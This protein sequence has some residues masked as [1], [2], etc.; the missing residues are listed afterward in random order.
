MTPDGRFLVFTSFRDLTPDDTSTVQQVFEYDAQTGGL[1][2]VS[3]GE[4]GFNHNGNVPANNATIVTPFYARNIQRLDL[5]ESL[6]G[7]RRWFL[8]VLPKYRRSHPASFGSA[9]DRRDS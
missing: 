9:G 2:R 7:V 1:V 5:L 8:C 3:V 4:D 6:V